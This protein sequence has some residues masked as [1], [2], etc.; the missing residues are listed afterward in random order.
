[1][2]AQYL[3]R[4]NTHSLVSHAIYHSWLLKL[5]EGLFITL[6]E[7]GVDANMELVKRKQ[8]LDLE[9]EGEFFST[10]SRIESHIDHIDQS[11]T[12]R[13]PTHPNPNPLTVLHPSKINSEMGN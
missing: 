5:L 4:N 13:Y 9:R 10:H 8:C 1:M 2:F 12:Q 6:Q 3:N 11:K 7:S